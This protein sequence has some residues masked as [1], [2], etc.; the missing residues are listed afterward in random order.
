MCGAGC[1]PAQQRTAVAVVAA[2]IGAR[3]EGLA[4]RGENERSAIRIG[5]ERL[6]SG[7]E[8]FDQR[9]VEKIV[10]RPPDLDQC[11]MAGL[12][13]ADIFEGSHAGIPRNSNLTPLEFSVSPKLARQT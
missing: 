11:H 4:L 8:L 9:D 3:A 5:I 6:K 1:R 2:E 13:Y 10:W 7:S 12:L